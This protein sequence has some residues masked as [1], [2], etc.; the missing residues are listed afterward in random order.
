MFTKK[1]LHPLAFSKLPEMVIPLLPKKPVPIPDNPLSEE[2][3]TNI[4]SKLPQ[5][6]LEV[7]FSAPVTYLPGRRDQPPPF[8]TSSFQVVVQ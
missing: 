1:L 3:L 8:P 4:K 6:Q 2:F 5:V 7:I